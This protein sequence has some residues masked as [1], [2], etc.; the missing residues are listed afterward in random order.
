LL[1]GEFTLDEATLA[2]AGIAT[3]FSIKDWP[4]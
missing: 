2:D 1:A 3:A 4:T